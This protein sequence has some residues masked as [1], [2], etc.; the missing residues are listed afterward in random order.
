MWPMSAG[1]EGV[2]RRQ[3]S[4]VLGIGEGLGSIAALEVG[5]K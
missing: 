2:L 5:L 1:K 4:R 3:S